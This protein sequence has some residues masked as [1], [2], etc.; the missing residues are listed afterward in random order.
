MAHVGHKPVFEDGRVRT[1]DDAVRVDLGAVPSVKQIAGRADHSDFRPTTEMNALKQ[2]SHARVAGLEHFVRARQRQSTL[3]SVRAHKVAQLRV[4]CAERVSTDVSL[5]V[6]AEDGA[7]V[8]PPLRTTINERLPKA[9]DDRAVHE[10][11]AFARTI[12]AELCF[13]SQGW[14]VCSVEHLSRT[15]GV[16]ARGPTLPAVALT[17]A[18]YVVGTWPRPEFRSEATQI[19]FAGFA[20]RAPKFRINFDEILWG[21]TGGEPGTNVR[22]PYV[23]VV[24]VVTVVR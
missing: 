17:T 3:A 1:E 15:R 5:Q 18:R 16:H 6:R 24:T 14:S 23:T 4:T 10:P 22:C 7:A 11:R 8:A 9:C 2:A 19:S 12:S 20:P 21:T 13:A